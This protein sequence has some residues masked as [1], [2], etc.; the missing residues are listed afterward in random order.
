M[1]KIKYSRLADMELEDIYYY[2]S[3]DNNFYAVEVVKSE[4]LKKLEL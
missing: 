1:Y 2:I 3:E 4:F